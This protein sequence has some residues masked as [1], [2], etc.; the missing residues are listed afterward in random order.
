M[1]RP[2]VVC[3]TSLLRARPE[4]SR[5]PMERMGWNRVAAAI[6]VLCLAS[7]AFMA[8]PASPQASTG[9]TVAAIGDLGISRETERNVDLAAA[10]GAQGILGLGDYNYDSSMRGWNA[11]MDPLTSRGAWFALG[12][13][14][15]M[16]EV[17]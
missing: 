10:N 8:M 5:T 16:D 7:V 3:P 15:R 1:P 9:L 12:N 4:A 6:A 17:G 13:H 2:T 11:V 14:D